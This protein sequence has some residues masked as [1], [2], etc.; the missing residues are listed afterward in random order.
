MNAL[1][2]SLENVDELVE[3][4]ARSLLINLI[5]TE[6]RTEE[7]ALCLSVARSPVRRLDLVA[8]I[9]ECLRVRGGV[10]ALRAAALVLF[11]R[12]GPAGALLAECERALEL[13]PGLLTEDDRAELLD[14]LDGVSLTVHADVPSLFVEATR[15]V[16]VPT[17]ASTMA[18]AVR[19]LERRGTAVPLLR[20][21]E[22]LANHSHRNVAVVDLRGWIDAHLDLVEA[23][24]RA[25]VTALRDAVRSVDARARTCLLVRVEPAEDDTFV[26]MA[27]LGQTDAPFGP[28]CGPEEVVT[29]GELQR[30]LREFVERY[31]HGALDPRR[32]PVIEF[33]LPP[34][35]LNEPVDTWKLAGGRRMGA[36]YQVVVRPLTRPASALPLVADRW[37]VLVASAGVES[38]APES[39]RWLHSTD[40]VPAETADCAAWAWIAVTCPLVGR[41]PAAVDAVLATG[42]PV[43][44]WL[45][46]EHAETA[47][48]AVLEG[49]SRGRLV[50]QL[51]D[52]VR[53]F[54]AN[55]WH[56]GSHHRDLVLLWDD[57]TRPPPSSYLV[58]AP[59][60]RT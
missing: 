39:M 26:V 60:R 36:L 24:R 40:D 31:A 9:R 28:N 4:H 21:L 37:K 30:W 20:F 8:L 46:G 3:P 41:Q 18:G 10:R 19:Q 55:G 45:R 49:L 27:W 56:D 57:P 54:R 47:R 42:A 12:A 13:E 52:A 16:P 50:T 29:L 35:H 53:K 59:E 43:A 14:L 6:L 1:V 11:D 5:E 2:A 33:A 15:P 32:R 38:P 48:R 7:P 22:L 25:E 34:S 44:V 17:T 51:P 23:H 58:N